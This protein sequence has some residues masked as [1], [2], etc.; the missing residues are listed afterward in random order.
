MRESSIQKKNLKF[1]R[2][3]LEKKKL[4][5]IAISINTMNHGYVED[6]DR[7]DFGKKKAYDTFD[8]QNPITNKVAPISILKTQY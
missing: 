1:H 3:Y 4:E 5:A 2:L 6:T 8:T 7:M